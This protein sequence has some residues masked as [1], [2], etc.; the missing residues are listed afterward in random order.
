MSVLDEVWEGIETK[1][2][3]ALDA[4]W[5][6]AGVSNESLYERLRR[7]DR[8]LFLRDR[9]SE[10][11]RA[12]PM[13]QSQRVRDAV[14]TAKAL[15]IPL[16]EATKIIDRAYQSTDGQ[17]Q[18]KTEVD[19]VRYKNFFDEFS[20]GLERGG[21]RF[22]GS[23]AGT[24]ASA[25]RAVARSPL[26]Y[27]LTRFGPLEQQAA[28]IEQASRPV[29]AAAQALYDDAQRWAVQPGK[30]GGFVGYIGATL[31]DTLPMMATAA[32]ATVATGPVGGFLVAGTA[33]GDSAYREAIA[34]GATPEQAEL[35]RL[36]VGTINGTI[37]LAQVGQVLRLGKGAGKEVARAFA[38][39]AS[40]RA[41]QK[42]AKAAGRVTAASVVNAMEEGVEEVAQEWVGEGAAILI[43]DKEFDAQ[44]MLS[45][46]GQAFAGGATAGLFLGGGSIILNAPLQQVTQKTVEVPRPDMVMT[47][48]QYQAYTEK[49]EHIAPK[50]TVA[51]PAAPVPAEAPAE[52]AAPV[53]ETAE[54]PEDKR[55]IESLPT[56]PG[57]KL[58]GAR[59]SEVT[60]VGV[61]RETFGRKENLYYKESNTGAFYTAESNT[62]DDYAV[63]KGIW[64][65]DNERGQGKG[66]RLLID[67]IS[68][69]AKD[70]KATIISYPTEAMKSLLTKAQ[71]SGEIAVVP[72][73]DLANAEFYRKHN[74]GL[75]EEYWKQQGYPTPIEIRA[76]QKG[77]EPAAET[78]APQVIETTPQPEVAKQS[79]VAPS[80]PGET[81]L[82]PWEMDS[83]S[84]DFARYVTKNLSQEE[85]VTAH[86][87]ALKDAQIQVWSKEIEEHR[88]EIGFQN[89]LGARDD[90]I[91]EREQKIAQK[92]SDRMYTELQRPFI[93]QAIEQGQ[94]V[95]R[96]VLEEYQSEP[97]A[98][99][100]IAKQQAQPTAEVQGQEGVTRPR[101][102]TEPGGVPGLKIPI[103]SLSDAELAKRLETATPYRHWYE[104]EQ[105][106]RREE[107]SK[108]RLVIPT[109][110]PEGGGIPWY[111]SLREAMRQSKE[112]RP[113]VVREQR[114]ERSR[115]AAA[116]EATQRWLRENG[117]SAKEALERG[118]VKFRGPLTDYQRYEPASKYLSEEVINMMYDDVAD[119]PRL[120]PYERSVTKEALDKLLGGYMLAPYEAEYLKKWRPE[121]AELVEPRTDKST[122]Y[123]RIMGIWRAGLLTGIKTSGLNTLSNMVHGVSEVVKDVPAAAFDT[124]QSLYTGERKLVFTTKGSTAGVKEGIQRGWNYLRTGVDERQSDSKWEHYAINY[125]TSPTAK[126]FRAYEETIFRIMGAEDMPFY[127]AAKARSLYNQS[128]A[129]ARNSNLKGADKEAYL[130]DVL[131][132]PTDDMITAAVHDAE[133]AVFQNRTALG[134]IGA[135]IQQAGGTIVVPFSRTPSALAMQVF[136]YTPAGA[137]KEAAQQIR[138]G[139]YDQRLMS[140]A[141][142][143]TTVGTGALY[144]GGVLLKNGLMSLGYPDNER[145]RELWAAE[146]RKE[147]AIKIGNKWRSAYVL[148]PIGNVLLIGGYIEQ[149]MQETGSATKAMSAAVAGGAKTLMDETFLRGLNQTLEALNDPERSWDTYFSTLAGSAVPTIV[150]DI[151]RA[152]DTTERMSYGPLDRVKSRIPGLRETLQ[153]RVNV[154]GNDVPRYG[155]NP[156][157]VMIDPTRPVKIRDDVVVDELRRLWDN[158][159][160][161]APTKVG[162][163]EGYASLTEY[164]NTVLWRRA[165]YL[166]YQ[167]LHNLIQQPYYEK[168]PDEDKGSRIERV[169]GEAKNLAR[170]EAAAAKMEA[171]A[172]ESELME[173]GLMNQTVKRLLG[174]AKANLAN[175]QR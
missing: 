126:A 35:E 172:T 145:E 47:E 14:S 18:V 108:P 142:G 10:A 16:S 148:G 164:E 113:T 50:E 36:V 48:E 23:G 107:R 146:G 71:A 155:G 27:P 124:L 32:A 149:S 88:N 57:L 157:E 128:L 125:G 87:A 19:R 9:M 4:E 81:S 45:R 89:L 168:L 31:G 12:N 7:E 20:K 137:I 130:Q 135:A 106:F 24:T 28:G 105:G 173:D 82:Q 162:N 103:A 151:A 158:D 98:Q 21:E 70:G 93:Q 83:Q 17:A 64:V 43:H 96:R 114:K 54:T 76:T 40:D 136:N 79:R 86:N 144:L 91:R 2:N 100:A 33:E 68:E 13:Q 102:I 129:Q 6:K 38:K 97:W 62:G 60:P 147:N 92:M 26:F 160:R 51:E 109:A 139:K 69:N 141:L 75:T 73:T 15:G 34:G 22:I 52:P 133:V 111:Q 110:T 94:P 53:A 131:T 169:V 78:P 80:Q 72:R 174:R 25:L 74:E 165:G 49:L 154:F 159:V 30:G 170:A 161:V 55:S 150:A 118:S 39:E 101:E 121:L 65:P 112:I 11:F 61:S 167:G 127:Y 66:T 156:L 46:T 29:E 56:A 171:G 99:E 143:R 153:P 44:E 123:Q 59:P 41:L 85:I 8:G 42:I 166:T 132:H 58:S 67:A 115:R 134:D 95:P 138:K 1:P 104:M 63:M 117:V 152:T 122:L 84:E 5:Q 3:T 119:T 77:A 175:Q 140:Q 90:Y 163:R 37:E 120:R 116:F